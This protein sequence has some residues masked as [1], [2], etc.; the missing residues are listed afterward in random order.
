MTSR[1][2]FLIIILSLILTSCKKNLQELPGDDLTHSLGN[3]EAT[4]EAIQASGYT[5]A[6]LFDASSTPYQQ[7]LA[8]GAGSHYVTSDLDNGNARVVQYNSSGTEVKRSGNLA[9]GH[10]SEASYRQANGNLYVAGNGNWVRE[11]DMRLGTPA[12]IRTIDFSQVGRISM[13]AVDNG[14]GR[15][16]VFVGPSGGPYAITTADFSGKVLSKFTYYRDPDERTPGME[17]IGNEILIFTAKKD[18]SSNNIE[19]FS[20]TGTKL[21]NIPVPIAAEG[22]GLSVDEATRTVYIGT[23]L[24]NRV[25]RMSPAF[26]STALLGMNLII[27]PNAEGGAGGTGASASVGI[28]FWTATG[29]TV[30]RYGTGSNPSATSPGSPARRSNFFAGG[31]V[32]SG[33]LTQ[34]V[35]VSNLSADIDAGALKY[36][37]KGWLGGYSSQNDNAKVTATFLSGSNA[38]LGT[39]TI[40]PVL[41]VDRSSTTGMVQRSKSATVPR[42]T[43]SVSVRVTVTRTAG[44]NCD[45]YADDL[46]LVLTRP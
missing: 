20:T 5:F 30:I 9:L 21:Y 8:F 4:N 15:L 3:R 24:P 40:G 28:P 22:E 42:G 19:V 16:V 29:T 32:A 38:S 25:Y 45:G 23:Q 35:N 46:S 33:T 36:S 12:I 37:L 34:K 39:A 41:A 44:T 43:R 1:C 2:S 6:K 18:N 26:K 14:N 11:V 7:G 31:T 10:A 17:V 27:N 13:V